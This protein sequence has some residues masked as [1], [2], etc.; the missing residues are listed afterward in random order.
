MVE[1]F[2]PAHNGSL[3]EISLSVKAFINDFRKKA[4]YDY[5][6]NIER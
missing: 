4:P 6:R 1:Q 5:Y 2:H 3:S